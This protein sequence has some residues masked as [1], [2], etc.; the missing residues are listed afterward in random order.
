MASTCKIS[1]ELCGFVED[2]ILQHTC[3]ICKRFMCCECSVNDAEFV[4]YAKAH[5]KEDEW[6]YPVMTPEENPEDYPRMKFILCKECYG[7]TCGEASKA[8]PEWTRR[9]ESLRPLGSYKDIVA[10]RLRWRAG[11][12][13]SEPTPSV[14]S[15][16]NLDIT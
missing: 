12:K 15:D 2:E 8:R 5:E 4:R 10:E 9:P 6:C 1:C 3:G 14:P 7:V 11:T 16:K 13:D